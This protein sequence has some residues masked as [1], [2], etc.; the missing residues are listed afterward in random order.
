MATITAT[1]IGGSGV[2]TVTETTMTASDTLTYIPGAGQILR[3]R[4]AT[5]GA[6]TVTITGSAAVSRTYPEGGTVN[7]AA[8]FSTGSIGATTGD[9]LV[10]LDSI[11]A[12]LDGTVTLTGGT[13]I[14]AS[15]LNQA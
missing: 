13:G 3:L 2:K 6:L 7:Y 1:S 12:Y 15:L 5:A 9:V 10:K 8:G 14:K 4:N 11:S